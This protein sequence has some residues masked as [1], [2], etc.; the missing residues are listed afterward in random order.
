M[1]RVARSL[2]THRELILN[3]FRANGQ[4]S[5]AIAEG[6]NNRAKVRCR[7][8]HGYRTYDAMEVALY[9]ELGELPQPKCL[10]RFA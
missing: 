6:K 9:H 7:M 10:H 1:K 5:A 2:R 4:I 8:A 3:W